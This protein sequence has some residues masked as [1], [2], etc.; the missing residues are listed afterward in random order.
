MI[1]GSS[2]KHLINKTKQYL[3][4][5]FWDLL[6]THVTAYHNPGN[7]QN[8]LLADNNRSVPIVWRLYA[9]GV[10][11][12]EGAHWIATENFVTSPLVRYFI[13]N[14]HSSVTV[15]VGQEVMGMFRID[16]RKSFFMISMVKYWNRLSN[17]AVGAPSLEIFKVRLV[18]AMSNL[19]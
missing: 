17:M 10:L 2:H 11:K 12:Q 4:V 3:H 6:L 1:L 9:Q 8:L 13:K 15:L 19:I 16:I 18:G 5:F 7:T 14:L